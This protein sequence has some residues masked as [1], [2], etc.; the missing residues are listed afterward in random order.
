MLSASAVADATRA[1]P[2]L[3]RVVGF[4]QNG[5]PKKSPPS[6]EKYWAKRLELYTERDCLMWGDRVVV[7]SVLRGP[8]LKQ[9]HRLHQ[10][11]VRTKRLARLHLW[12]PDVNRHIEELIGAC[13]VCQTSRPN[14]PASPNLSLIHI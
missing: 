13:E 14:K 3:S 1:D 11:I 5:W 2:E 8:A 4:V 9:L 12:W 6:L 7:P 10:G